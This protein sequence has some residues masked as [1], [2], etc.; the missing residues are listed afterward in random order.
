M[1][2]NL[3]ISKRLEVLFLKTKT[4][5]FGRYAIKVPQE[6]E[7]I[8]GNISAPSRIDIIKGGIVAKD[9]KNSRRHKKNKDQ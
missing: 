7:L 8:Y 9:E 6:A 4:V 5:C 1:S 3:K 2:E